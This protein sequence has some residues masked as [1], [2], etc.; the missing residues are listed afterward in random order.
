MELRLWL[1]RLK[2]VLRVALRRLLMLVASHVV[3]ATP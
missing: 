2:M 1:A 3:Q